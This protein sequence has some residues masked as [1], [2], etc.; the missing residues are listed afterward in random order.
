[1]VSW[2]FTGMRCR[3]SWQSAIVSLELAL[4]FHRYDLIS[5]SSADESRA[6]PEVGCFIDFVP[7]DGTEGVGPWDAQG[8][9]STDK[10]HRLLLAKS[11]SDL[12]SV[13]SSDANVCNVVAFFERWDCVDVQDDTGD[14]SAGF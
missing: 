2:R 14:G 13:G 9:V 3:K 1:M 10:D 8:N 7:A 4:V 12:G 5:V 11:R 6:N